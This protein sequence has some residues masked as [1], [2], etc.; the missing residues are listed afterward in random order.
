MIISGH[1]RA[2]IWFAEILFWAP[3][4]QSMYTFPFCI[5]S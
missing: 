1:H 5:N 3:F 4:S 2:E